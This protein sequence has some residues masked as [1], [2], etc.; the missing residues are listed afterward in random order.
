MCRTA[1]VSCDNCD[2]KAASGNI[3]WLSILKVLD[4]FI[5][6]ILS[7]LAQHA[8]LAYWQGPNQ[9]LSLDNQLSWNYTSWE[10]IVQYCWYPHT[11]RPHPHFIVQMVCCFS[12][13]HNRVCLVGVSYWC[14]I[15]EIDYKPNTHYNRSMLQTTTFSY[16]PYDKS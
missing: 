12:A 6:S 14:T 7:Y 4:Q 8:H 15:S 10:L 9:L 2:P 11:N 16:V 5:S 13:I 3:L 1:K